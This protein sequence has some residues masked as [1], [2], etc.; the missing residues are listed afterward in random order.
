MAQ[1]KKGKNQGSIEEENTLKT[2]R[3]SQPLSLP[4]NL[5]NAGPQRF[6]GFPLTSS[7]SVILEHLFTPDSSAGEENDQIS[8]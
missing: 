8:L 2:D 6:P 3:T 5:Q 7:L 4:P 1:G